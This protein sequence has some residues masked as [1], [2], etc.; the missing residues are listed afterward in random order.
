MTTFISQ[1]NIDKQ[2]LSIFLRDLAGDVKINLKHMIE[3]SLITDNTKNKGH[4]KKGKQVIKKKDIIIQQQN[5]KRKK[6]YIED[7][8]NKMDFLINNM[9]IKK[10]FLQMNT[11]K[12]EEGIISYKFRL[13]D[14]FWK[15]K[16]NYMNYIILLFFELKNTNVRT[17]YISE[18]NISL[19]RKINETLEESDYKIFM[20]K[21]LGHMLPP[22][23]YWDKGLKKFDD[24][25][26]NVIKYVDQKKSVI[27]RAPTSSGKTFIAMSTGIIHKKIIYICPAKPVAYQVGANF[28]HMGYKVHFLVDNLSHYSYTS[29]TN[30]FIGTPLEVEDYLNKVGCSFDY[31]V[32]DEIHNLNKEEDGHNYENIIKL[33]PCNFLALSATIKNVDYLQD[34]FNKIHP[35]MKI[36][37]VEYNKRFI[38][39]N[40]WIW[41]DGNLKQLHPLC[42]FNNIGD[43]FK[44]SPLQ[45]TPNN[46]AILWEK[47]EEIFEEIDDENDMLDECSPDEYFT[48]SKLLTL[49]DCK[50]YESFL[51]EKLFEWNETY[52]EEIQGLFDL[53]KIEPVKDNKS[54]IIDFIR[55]AKKK[56]MFPMLMF[57]TDENIC[58]GIF[59]YIYEYLDKKELE[60]YPY[61]YE[62]LEKKDE[63]FTNYLNKREQFKLNIKITSTNAHYEIKEKLEEFERKEK[64]IYVNNILSFYET[65]LSD[66]NKREDESIKSIQKKNLKGEMD[67]FL[68]NPDFINQ[69]VFKKHSEFIFTDSNEPMSGETI[70]DVRREIK[71]TL[72]I[73]IPYESPLFQMLK[74]GIGLYIE[75]A[76]DE[77]NWILQKLLSKKEIGIV[78]SDKTLCLG[79]DLPVRTSC[80]L[81]IEGKTFT[82]DE[83]LQMSGRAGR[84]G[85]D[86]K[87][88]IIFYGEIDY[89]SLM[90]SDLPEIIGST[91]SICDNYRIMDKKN[92]NEGIFEN[93]INDERK[94]EKIPNFEKPEENEKLLWFLREYIDASYFITNL[95]KLETELFR[96]NEND[97]ERS[98]LDKIT[99]IVKDKNN[100]VKEYYKLK[101][102]D[103][104]ENIN[105]VKEH[106]KVIKHIHNNIN[107]RKYMIIVETSKKLFNDLN[108]MIFGLII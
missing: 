95:M 52:P 97:R 39:H 99:R 6:K 62:I 56:D 104:Y 35:E 70:R 59:E 25:Q 36:K 107:N 78:I 82:K 76:P 28:I 81:G 3:D 17:E 12:S 23:N 44:E 71:S 21:N 88:N 63:L 34:I 2:K 85:L 19:L 38:N 69:D 105:I 103:N 80:F 54:N 27:V 64:S 108:K 83:Y 60:E 51:K 55:K 29:Q 84:R 37:Y 20:M 65:K 58:K 77:Y 30:I 24:W 98:L 43:S 33:L 87:G 22:L 40:R 102:I 74:R 68:M 92:Y 9:N 53:F 67:E 73:K 16:D 101:K 49:D 31:A 50:D 46:C 5:E 91:K 8:M 47:I 15:D 66:I 48:E 90:R 7:D 75:N 86:N 26:K 13:L 41:K 32:F 89:L 14:F 11:L 10:P 42:A 79:I 61:H 93:M 57:N 100:K 96:M 1:Q 94:Y 72:G 45:F 106:M 4:K 18:N